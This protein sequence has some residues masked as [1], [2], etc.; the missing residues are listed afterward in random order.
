MKSLLMPCVLVHVRPCVHPSNM[1]SLF[2]PV[3]WRASDQVLLASKAKCP[4]DDS[5]P[6]QTPDQEPDVKLKTLGLVQVLLR[7]NFSTVCGLSP[8]RV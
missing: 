5:S 3:L 7:Y 8:W 2:P 1:E 6:W 4:G